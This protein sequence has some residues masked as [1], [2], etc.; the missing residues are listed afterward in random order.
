[1][2]SAVILLMFVLLASKASCIASE[3]SM[4]DTASVTADQALIKLL[5]GNTRFCSW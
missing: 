5:E 1:M 3:S 2:K 4:K